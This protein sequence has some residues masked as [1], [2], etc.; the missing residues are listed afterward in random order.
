MHGVGQNMFI[1]LCLWDGQDTNKK[2]VKDFLQNIQRHIKSHLLKNIYLLI[3]FFVISSSP[4]ELG[5]G[6]FRLSIARAEEST[7]HR[8]TF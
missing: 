4:A 7:L 1:A 3:I 2:Q 6:H 5:S 8:Y